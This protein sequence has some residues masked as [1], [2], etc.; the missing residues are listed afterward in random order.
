MRKILIYISI[1]LFLTNSF[2]ID[3]FC[4]TEGCILLGDINNDDVITASDALS[5]LKVVAKI[6]EMGN[7]FSIRKND[8]NGD[9][10]IDSEDALYILKIASKIETKKTRNDPNNFYSN[11][12]YSNGYPVSDYIS[13]D[14]ATGE[15]FSIEERLLDREYFVGLLSFYPLSGEWLGYAGANVYTENFE[16]M[17]WEFRWLLEDSINNG[18]LKRLDVKSSDFIKNEI[19]GKKEAFEFE[20][21]SVYKQ[22]YG[23]YNVRR[24]TRIMFYLTSDGKK[25]ISMTGRTDLF[26]VPEDEFY[27]FEYVGDIP[28]SINYNSLAKFFEVNLGK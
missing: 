10:K 4:S 8:L 13:C 28:E 27:I 18:S 24:S 9:Y 20:F 25:Y 22:S 12:E 14:L 5:V 26:I 17:Y 11:V 21:K 15:E 3:S 16:K 6:E 19:K 7:S 2:A 1:A 23:S